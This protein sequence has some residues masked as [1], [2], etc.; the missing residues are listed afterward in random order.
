MM[1]KKAIKQFVRETLGCTCP[2]EVVQHIDCRASVEASVNILLDYEINI[3]DRLLIFVVNTDEAGSLELL[4]PQLVRNGTE[5]R[6]REHFNRF[7]L[8][9]LTEEPT[10]IAEEA[11][12]IFQFLDTDEKVHLHV[13]AKDDLAENDLYAQQ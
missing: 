2:D 11:S 6:N 4:I 12:A 7:R 5:R 8:V 10:D 9:L 1:S 3:G 13:V